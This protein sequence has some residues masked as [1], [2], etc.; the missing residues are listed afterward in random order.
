M[1]DYERGWKDCEEHRIPKENESAEY[2]RGYG[3]RYA[4]EQDMNELSDRE[5][6]QRHERMG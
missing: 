3:D 4:A 6:R 1:N 2:N 5:W